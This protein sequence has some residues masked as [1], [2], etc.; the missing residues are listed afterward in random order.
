MLGFGL[1][2]WKNSKLTKQNLLLIIFQVTDLCTDQVM[3]WLLQVIVKLHKVGINSDMPIN[4]HMV[5]QVAQLVKTFSMDLI[6]IN[7]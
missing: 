2:K 6:T 1:I 3:I 7:A 4:V 5:A